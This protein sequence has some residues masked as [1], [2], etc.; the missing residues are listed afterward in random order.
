[1]TDLPE[2]ALRELKTAAL[3]RSLA[4]GEEP[5]GPEQTALLAF[6]QNSCHEVPLAADL[7]EASARIVDALLRGRERRLQQQIREASRQGDL[8]L[9]QILNR[10]KMA[11]LEQIQALSRP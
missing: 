1:M 7:E 3:L 4:A 10:E 5:E 11:V 2:D 8:G 6:I 9:V